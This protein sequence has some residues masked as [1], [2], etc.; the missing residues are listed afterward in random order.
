MPRPIKIAE[1]SNI[2]DSGYARK[3]TEHR[4]AV[5]KALRLMAEDL[6]YNSLRTRRMSGHPGIWEAHA[7]LQVVL[8]FDFVAANTVRLRACCTHDIYRN[9]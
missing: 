2:F 3:S 7:S 9:P 4:Q 5:D 1:A 8:T 6:H